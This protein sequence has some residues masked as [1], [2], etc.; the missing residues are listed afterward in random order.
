MKVYIDYNGN[1]HSYLESRYGKFVAAPTEWI[2]DLDAKY[3]VGFVS[4]LFQE[5]YSKPLIC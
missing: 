4:S 3:D 5:F 1:D 2:K